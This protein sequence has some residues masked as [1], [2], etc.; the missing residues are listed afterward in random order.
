M[1]Y[2]WMRTHQNHYWNW[3]RF[4]RW[5]TGWVTSTPIQKLVCFECYGRGNTRTRFYYIDREQSQSSDNMFYIVCKNNFCLLTD[6]EREYLHEKGPSPFETP[7]P[8]QRAPSAY[9]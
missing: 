3:N 1:S 5:Y 2:K 6:K 4:K 8:S 9:F 7:K